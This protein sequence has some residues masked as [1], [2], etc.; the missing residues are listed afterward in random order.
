MSL[1]RA[2]FTQLETHWSLV[3]QHLCPSID[4]IP[5]GGGTT[6]SEKLSTWRSKTF[7]K[8]TV[9]QVEDALLNA[10]LPALTAAQEAEQDKVASLSDVLQRLA[11]SPLADKTPD[12]IYTIMQAQIDGWGSLA[13]AKADMRVW[14]PLMAAAIFWLARRK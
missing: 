10:V 12:E 8:P 11:D 3:I 7:A 5:D 14:F 9:E 2:E 4:E 13:A 6:I 1:T